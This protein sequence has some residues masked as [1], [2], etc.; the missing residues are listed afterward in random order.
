MPQA[1]VGKRGSPIGAHLKKVQ[2]VAIAASVAFHA[3]LTAGLS[4]MAYRSLAVERAEAPQVFESS[5]VSTTI[6]V[7][8]PS[9]GDGTLVDEESVDPSSEP[10][11]MMAGDTVAHLDTGAPGRGGEASVR[12]PA[13]NLADGD[14]RM[15][16]SPDL[17]SR[18][19][20]DQLQRLR[21]ARARASW[22]DRRSTTHPA[23]LTLVSTGPGAVRERRP[24][25]AYE[26][27]RGAVESP[28]AS[29]RGA[30]LGDRRDDA[31]PDGSDGRR[32]GATLGT[33]VGA[34]GRGLFAAPAGL[35]HRVSAPVASARPAVAPGPVAM[36]AN[37]RARPRDNVE[38]EQEVATAIQALVHA[39]TAGGVPGEGEGGSAGSGEAG[40]GA[41]S[42]AGSRARPLG[43]GEGDVYDYWTTDPRLL[44]YFRQIHAKIDPLWADAFPKS[45]LFELKQG[46]VIIELTI[47]ADGQV[48]VSW[49]PVRPSGVEE[50][51]RNCAEAIR[52]AAP[53]PPIP[54]ELGARRLRIRAPFVANNPIVK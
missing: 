23:E 46:T 33:I 27:N 17:L 22:E 11:R 26:P 9:I 21:V 1:V 36:P 20:R 54:R 40:A 12:S 25:A 18:L 31:A 29:V 24:M 35:D 52:R 4:W 34:P 14:E 39:S 16:L 51:D 48:A 8:L 32:G 45:A 49:P 43:L 19:D 2:A 5:P 13:L 38:S 7:E 47:L 10:P 3:A 28:S 15:R 53:F 50:F 37:A 44:P 6:A 41:M 42:G 30:S